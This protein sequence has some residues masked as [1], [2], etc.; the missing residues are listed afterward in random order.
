MEKY[1]YIDGNNMDSIRRRAQKFT[2]RTSINEAMMVLHSSGE[3]M[4]S[5]T[6]FIAQLS[7]MKLSD[8][9]SF[10]DAYELNSDGEIKWNGGVRGI[11]KKLDGT[12][13]ELSELDSMEIARIKRVHEKI[14]GGYRSD[15]YCGMELYAM[16]QFFLALKKYFPRIILNLLQGKE[17]DTFLGY[18]KNVGKDKIDGK[19]VDVYQ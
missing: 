14:L 12:S 13:I 6:S 1:N 2:E 4:A 9:R 17:V 15:E 11:V 16:G 8:G 5:T 10:Y 7:H 18:Y 3:L 19:E